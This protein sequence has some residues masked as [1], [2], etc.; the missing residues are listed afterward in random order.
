[1]SKA[2]QIHLV[3][4][5]FKRNKT[6]LIGASIILV[7][8]ALAILAPVVS[9]YDPGLIRIKDKNLPPSQEHWMG[10]DQFGRDVFSFVA[11]GARESLGIA[12]GAVIIELVIAM[13][14]GALAGYYGGWI[15]EV[16]MR[17]TDIILTLPELVLL[18]VAVSMFEVRSSIIVMAV[19]GVISWPWLARIVR[20]EF[21]ALKEAKFVEA[22]KSFGATDT[23]IIVRH[24]LPNTL[25]AVI[26]FVTMDLAWFILYPTTLA[27]LGLG[28]PTAISWGTLIYKGK[29]YLRTA[30]WITTFPGLFIFFTALGFNLLGDGLRDA[31]DVKTMV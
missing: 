31:L 26:V 15:D 5:K 21:L 16:L 11:F 10:T 22:A 6:T 25:S 19:I 17:I 27:F 2:S 29:P 7:I 24:I 23:R 20:G 14:I 30:W 12:L 4:R 3:W 13:L 9:P 18:I 28:D 1:M 8:V